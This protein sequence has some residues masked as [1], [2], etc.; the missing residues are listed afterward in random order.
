MKK[1][2]YLYHISQLNAVCECLADEVIIATKLF[3]RIGRISKNDL[4]IT[5]KKLKGA[6]KRIVFEWD[7]LMTENVYRKVV[8]EFESL[9]LEDVDAFRVMDPGAINYLIFNET[10]PLQLNLE[11]SGFHNKKAIKKWIEL[12]NDRIERVILSIELEKDKIA[13]LINELDV[14]V[15][16]LGYGR[17]L[18]F[19]T[20]RSLIQP[21]YGSDND[22]IEVTANSEESPHKGFP[23][24]EN[25]HGTFMFNTKEHY[26][27]DHIEDL[28]KIN[29]S[30]IRIDNRFM[31]NSDMNKVLHIISNNSNEDGLVFKKKSNKQL[32]RGFFHKNKSDALFKKL[33]NYRILRKDLNYVGEVID[34]S[35]NNHLGLFIRS[36]NTKLDKGKQLML[37]TP[38]GK[39][40]YTT[41]HSVFKSDNS[42]TSSQNYGDIIFIPHVSGISVKTNVYL[43]ED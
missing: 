40:K 3:S 28:Y 27:L 12:F 23:V 30:F 24:I 22:V 26:V 43:M 16:Y 10:R 4:S 9:N 32:I 36:K 7:I 14:P 20:P 15:E 41:L 35:K 2:V 19:Y 1:I 42:P 31:D 13:E 6:N 25:I 5:C 33:K 39:E 8:K 18:L 37:V 34:V 17:I 11:S 29:L 38:D 21:L